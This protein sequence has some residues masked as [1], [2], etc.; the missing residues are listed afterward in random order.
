MTILEIHSNIFIKYT[1]TGDDPNYCLCLLLCNN[2]SHLM[3]N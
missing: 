2:L 3:N 1:T